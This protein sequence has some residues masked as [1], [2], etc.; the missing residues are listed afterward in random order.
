MSAI[1][2]ILGSLLRAQDKVDVSARRI[3]SFSSPEGSAEGGPDVVEISAAA[4]ALLEARNAYSI[5]TK[6]L[7]T[8]LDTE[9]PTPPQSTTENP[10]G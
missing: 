8:V 9:L 6:V 1:P 2:E 3:A 7:S 4:V 10:F 5:N